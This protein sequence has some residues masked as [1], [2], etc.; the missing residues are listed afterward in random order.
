MPIRYIRACGRGDGVLGESVEKLGQAARRFQNPSLT[1]IILSR[2]QAQMTDGNGRNPVDAK[3][4]K[5]AN[6][7][8]LKMLSD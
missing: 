8:F 6:R 7:Q 1:Y 2:M 4:A 3:I 5:P